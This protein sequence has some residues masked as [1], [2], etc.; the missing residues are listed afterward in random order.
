MNYHIEIRTGNEQ[1]EPLNSPV[2]MQIYGITATT[3]K[4][5][6]ESKY[7]SFMK[8]SIAKF[9]I[10]SNNVGDIKKIVIGHENLG[11]INDWYLQDIKIQTAG[12][13]YEFV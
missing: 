10:S 5:F 2:Y 6:L 9:N 3:P 4:L 8:D 7:A 13:Q 1:I 11:I 12:Q